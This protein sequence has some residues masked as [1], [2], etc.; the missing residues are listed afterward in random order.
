MNVL[1]IVLAVIGGLFCAFWIL[2]LLIGVFGNKVAIGVKNIR[3]MLKQRGVDT[4]SLTSKQIKDI[5]SNAYWGA[6]VMKNG[7]MKYD[8]TEFQKQLTFRAEIVSR[9]LKEE[10]LNEDFV[11]LAQTLLGEKTDT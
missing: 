6:H 7:R 9:Y 10:P 4:N 2:S 8:A 1:I 3:F 5:A 11:G